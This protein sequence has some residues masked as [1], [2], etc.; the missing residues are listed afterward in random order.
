MFQKVIFAVRLAIRER[1]R[2]FGLFEPSAKD[3]RGITRATLHDVE[4]FV[5]RIQ[6]TDAQRTNARQFLETEIERERLFVPVEG[7]R[8][9]L[10]PLFGADSITLMIVE[11]SSSNLP[12]ESTRDLIDVMGPRI[13]GTASAGPAL[14]YLA[15]L[16]AA[17]REATRLS[18][19]EAG[20]VE[21]HLSGHSVA[22]NPN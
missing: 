14:A 19:R 7:D 13:A 3:A 8:I 9:Y 17:R 6:G 22:I 21:H 5:K 12:I 16:D 10:P 15:K 20:Y 4:K 18:A 1:L 11:T 2:R